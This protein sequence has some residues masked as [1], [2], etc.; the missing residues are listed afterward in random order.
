MARVDL[1][2][3]LSVVAFLF[4]LVGALLPAPTRAEAPPAPRAQPSPLEPQATLIAVGD[5]MLSR[6]VAKRIAENK[7]PNFPFLK[8]TDYLRSAD[9]TFGN[10]EC[11]ITEGPVVTRDAMKFHAHPGV[12]RAL[13][14]AGFSVLSLANNH[15]PDYGPKGVIRTTA[16]LDAVGITWVGA[17][18]DAEEAERPALV[19]KNGVRFAFLAYN[20]QDVVPKRYGAAKKHP[21]TNIM[22]KK[23]VSNAVRAAKEQADVVIVSMHS[24][25]E[26]MKPNAHQASFAKAAIDAGAEVVIGH[27]PHVVQSV[28]QYKGK[29]ILYSLGNFVF[30]QT[31]SPSVKQGV[32]VKIAFTRAGLRSMRFTPVLIEHE[33]QPRIITEPELREEVLGRLAWPLDADGT[34]LPARGARLA[35]Q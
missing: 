32:A 4:F 23:K 9:M 19:T 2:G 6:D 15:L 11:P 25:R 31:R 35:A 20:D 26:Y 14:Q 22:D 34:A 10:L 5:V 8:V 12:E 21:G 17:G 27:H 7:D 1:R 3:S 16:L 28:E 13:K 18:K 24:G 29:F 30:D 33:A